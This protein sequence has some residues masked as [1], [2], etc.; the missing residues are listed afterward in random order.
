MLN[1]YRPRDIRNYIIWRLIKYSLPYMSSEYTQALAD[2]NSVLQGWNVTAP[3]QSDVC[4]SYI[5]G[6]YEMPNL[7]FATAEAVI[8]QNYFPAEEKDVCLIY[9]FTIKL[10]DKIISIL[11]IYFSD[12]SSN[13]RS[14]E[15]WIIGFNHCFYLDG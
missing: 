5:K 11:R 8:K 4:L 12:S 7:G 14:S 13:G 3:E 9:I 15:K 6:N 1:R 2:F 10:K